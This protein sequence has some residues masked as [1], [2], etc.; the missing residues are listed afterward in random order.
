MGC[1]VASEYSTGSSIMP[2]KRNPDS[3]ELIR[4]KANIIRTKGMEFSNII[5][6]LPLT[7]F[8]DFQED[9]KIIFDTYDELFMCI[10]V[11]SEVIKG[12]RF[13]QDF[14]IQICND[15]HATATDLA[16]YLV[17]EKIPFRVSYKI[18]ANIVK[19]AQIK[20]KIYQN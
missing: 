4:S 1:L 20:I 13:N 18:I 14:G 2:Q 9:K 10:N 12:S 19:H 17:I 5:S 11:M 15:Y 16:D 6:G 7:Y 3:L 8:K